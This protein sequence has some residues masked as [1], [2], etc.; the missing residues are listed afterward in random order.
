[1][2]SNKMTTS[3]FNSMAKRV[4]DHRF[5]WNDGYTTGGTPLNE[6]LVW[7]FYFQNVWR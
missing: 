2:F 3:E 7:I 6:G 1:L 4:L 5:L